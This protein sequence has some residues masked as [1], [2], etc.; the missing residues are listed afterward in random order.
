MNMMNP[1]TC[2]RPNWDVP[3]QQLNSLETRNNERVD[4][5]INFERFYPKP[6]WG[7][8][9]PSFNQH[10][11]FTSNNCMYLDQFNFGRNSDR[12]GNEFFAE[13]N[14]NG[15]LNSFPEISHDWTHS[16]GSSYYRFNNSSGKFYK[17][18]YEYFT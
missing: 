9:T 4:C 5:F 1:H 8:Q 3:M 12:N 11:G 18:S 13:M 14:M 15:L 2:A 17:R 10:S 7:F 6:C 16:Y